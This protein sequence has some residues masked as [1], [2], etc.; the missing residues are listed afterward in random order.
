MMGVRQFFCAAPLNR[1]NRSPHA[2]RSFGHFGQPLFP[3]PSPIFWGAPHPPPSRHA[4][5][6]FTPPSVG[7]CTCSP[8]AHLL[9]EWTPAQFGQD[10][11]P[12]PGTDP[13]V[14]GCMDSACGLWC[15]VVQASRSKT[16]GHSNATRAHCLVYAAVL[17]RSA[18]PHRIQCSKSSS[19][20][21]ALAAL[22]VSRKCGVS[23]GLVIEGKC[24]GVR[25]T[26]GRLQP[27]L[28]RPTP[29]LSVNTFGGGRLSGNP[30][31]RW[32]YL[33]EGMNSPSS[34]AFERHV[35]GHLFRAVRLFYAPKSVRP[36]KQL[37]RHAMRIGRCTA[38]RWTSSGSS[39]PSHGL[40]LFRAAFC[41]SAARLR[42]SSALRLVVDAV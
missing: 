2:Q 1:T 37:K 10:R 11:S 24:N 25:S 13:L 30:H 16:R 34:S 9:Q 33:S 29:Q 36:G 8:A 12:R 4:D 38:G 40:G 39:S 14:A 22:A 23:E 21:P 41:S 32:G 15:M 26:R 28:M 5:L 19:G 20:E 31:N 35:P 3:T 17:L 7:T 42:F 27:V 6:F 18:D